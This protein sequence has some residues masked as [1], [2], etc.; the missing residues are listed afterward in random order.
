M[1]RTRS[2]ETVANQSGAQAVQPLDADESMPPALE[3]TRSESRAGA[4]RN[5]RV[6]A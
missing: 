6:P 5:R 3:A 2:E 4:D 1:Q